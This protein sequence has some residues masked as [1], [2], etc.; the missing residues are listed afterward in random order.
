MAWNPAHKTTDKTTSLQHF[1]DCEQSLFFA[2][3]RESE[4]KISERASLNT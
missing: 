1:Q 2:K 4:R 3:I